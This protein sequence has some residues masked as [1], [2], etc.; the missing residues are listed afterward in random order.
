GGG[1]GFGRALVSVVVGFDGGDVQFW[2]RQINLV[3]VV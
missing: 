3:M 1:M 2:W